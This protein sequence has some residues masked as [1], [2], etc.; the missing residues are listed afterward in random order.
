MNLLELETMIPISPS[1]GDVQHVEEESYV[2]LNSSQR[3]QTTLHNLQNTFI[4]CIDNPISVLSQTNII[5]IKLAPNTDLS[6]Y[7]QI[8]L[9]NIKLPSFTYSGILEIGNSTI[10]WEGSYN[11]Y[12]NIIENVPL[13]TPLSLPFEISNFTIVSSSEDILPNNAIEGI[14]NV[15]VFTDGTTVTFTLQS[16]E[17]K[18]PLSESPILASFHL[19][20]SHIGGIP[21]S[22]IQAN[23]PIDN[24][25]NSSSKTIINKTDTFIQINTSNSFALFSETDVG[26]SDIYI[27][28]IISQTTGYTIPSSYFSR[29][30][31]TY[32]NVSKIRIITS[33]FPC[34]AINVD[35]TTSLNYEGDSFPFLD[36]KSITPP[37][38]C[39][40]ADNLV[41]KIIE[42]MNMSESISSTRHTSR[43]RIFSYTNQNN[44]EICC[45]I[46]ATINVKNAITVT[47]GINKLEI[48]VP[49]HGLINGDKIRFVGVTPNTVESLYFQVKI[50]RINQNTF[51]PDVFIVQVTPQLIQFVNQ[52]EFIHIE[53]G[54][55]FRF[56]P[57]LLLPILGFPSIVSAYK[58]VHRASQPKKVWP[59]T[60]FELRIRPDQPIDGVTPVLLASDYTLNRI[61]VS[62]ELVGQYIIEESNDNWVVRFKPALA[63][64]SGINVFLVWPDGTNPDF[65]GAEHSFT[66]G[67][68]ELTSRISQQSRTGIQ[69]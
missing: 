24:L 37:K 12:I 35:G 69:R 18:W 49:S 47:E 66:I 44:V 50:T 13:S 15:L 51:N 19:K 7:D 25:H 62:E 23:L 4:T 46:Y 55:R 52:Q 17:R 67:I 36:Q 42:L 57:S 38:G 33:E 20:V 61:R 32:S 59:F 54:S 27:N 34:T 31:R 9:D 10:S 68:T 45:K 48:T 21:L 65:N 2:T 64:L 6:I 28:K 11:T 5:S 29:L 63:T 53:I 26:G 58:E 16:S 60:Y 30:N 1:D 56:S 40:S 41:K 39:Y 22:D 14:V 43:K 8:V 3:Q